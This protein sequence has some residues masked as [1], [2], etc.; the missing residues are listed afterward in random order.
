[1]GEITRLVNGDRGKNYP[2]KDKLTPI[3]DIPFISAINIKDNTITKDNLLYLSQHQYDLLRDGKLKKNDLVVCIRGSLGKNCIYPFETGAIASSLVIIKIFINENI[4]INYISV[5]FD[6]SLFKLD[7]NKYNNGS[8]QPNLGARDLMKFLIPLPPLEEQKRIVAKIEELLPL[9]EDYAAFYNE[10]EKLNAKF[11]EDIKKSILQ[12]AIQGKLV[13]QRKE[14][15]SA[16]KLFNQIQEEKQRLIKEGKIKKQKPLPEIKEDEIPFEIPKTWKWCRLGN[17]INHIMGKTPPRSE[18][19]WWGEDMPWVSISD[20]KDYGEINYTKESVCQEAVD[21]K[22][23]NVSKKGTLLMSFKL[24]VG[25]TSILNIDA[26]HN[27]AIISIYPYIDK[28]YSL[29][30]YLFYILP[31]ITQWGDSKKAIKGN[32]LNSSSI[33]SLL[34]PPP[35]LEEQKRI[36]A[37]IEELL[38]LCEELKI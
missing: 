4:I 19:K 31:L 9:V 5:Y 28:N 6:T 21:E 37:K 27:E 22:F 15:G 36:V 14:E 26:V 35:P 8:V 38:P 30:N 25:R 2:S 20:M 13:E 34:I 33:S 16:E 7:I 12:Y 17:L 3:G 18:F 32:T 29:R 23:I 1:M 10:L 24:T 11:P